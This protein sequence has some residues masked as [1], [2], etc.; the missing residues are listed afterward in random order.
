MAGSLLSRGGKREWRISLARDLG[1]FQTPPQLVAALLESLGPIGQKWRRVLEPTCGRG[2]FIAGLL[3]HA[4]PPR[5]IVGIE[6]QDTHV[7]SARRTLK[8]S[9][10]T[11]VSIKKANIFDTD[12]CQDL[13]WSE[14]GPLLVVGNLPWVTSSELGALRSDNLPPKSNLKGLRGIDAITG[15]SNFDIAEYIWIKLIRELAPEHPTIALLC[16]TSVARNV[17]QF[18]CE[19]GLPITG[20][21]IRKI[22]TKNWFEVAADGCLFCV[23][24]GSGGRCYEAAV[25]SEL[26]ASEPTSVIGVVGGRL[27]SDVTAYT[28]TAFADGVCP[29]T[30]R[31]GL[32][33]DAASV[34]ELTADPSGRFRNQLGKEV[35][36]EPEYV[37]PLL[38]S[39]DLYHG[40]RAHARRAVIVPQRR[41]SDDTRQ[42][43]SL[44][45]KLWGYLKAH[46]KIFKRRR[47]SVYRD[48]PPFALFGIGDYSFS[49]Y[50]VAVSGLHKHPRFRAIG[51]VEGRPVMLDDTCYLLP[52]YSPQ[53]AAVLTGLL[54]DPT[55]LE[56]IHSMV[57][58]D[59]KRPLT[60][61]ILQ[62]IDLKALLDR[63][64]RECLLARAEA[65]LDRLTPTKPREKAAWP[66]TFEELFLEQ[67]H[68]VNLSPPSA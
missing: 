63:V 61:K 58:W 15:G 45:P 34:M 12:L 55:C 18:A 36:V 56:L 33:H 7:R 29:F 68:Q 16:K 10:A 49:P 44:A 24:I 9:S 17:L 60:K 13:R 42:L 41:L 21:W 4:V 67:P 30:W 64:D 26:R 47:S 3:M 38:K 66:S 11:R 14:S 62:R 28:R 25:Y 40:P 52:C 22:D 27:V 65:E 59:S 53:Q 5:E 6:L 57:F 32:K 43:V 51:L 39:S 2:N 48:R 37:Y 23:E 35:A 50:K 31:Q 1:D 20:A 8:S 19:S 54:N 46:A